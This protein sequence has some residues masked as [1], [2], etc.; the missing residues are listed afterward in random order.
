MVKNDRCLQCVRK[1]TCSTPRQGWS[2]GAFLALPDQE[3][4]GHR[5]VSNVLDAPLSGWATEGKN[6]R[7]FLSLLLVKVWREDEGFNGKRPF[8]NS[9]WKSDVYKALVKAGALEGTL[10]ED[11]YLDD[12][13]RDAG[14]ELILA[15]IRDIFHA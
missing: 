12:C 8:G 3:P 15:A 4:G 13:D 11:G 2:A 10:D 6:V 5:E 7:E 1:R 14:D 9:G